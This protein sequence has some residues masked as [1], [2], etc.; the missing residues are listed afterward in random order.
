VGGTGGSFSGLAFDATGT[1]Y[2]M[3]LAVGG[4]GRL[5]HLVTLDPTTGGVTDVGPSITAID[6]MA[7]QPVPVPEPGTL[8]LLCGPVGLGL[9]RSMRRRR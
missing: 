4:G 1:L 7:F 5:T 8:A 2:G 9:I 6:A 3:N